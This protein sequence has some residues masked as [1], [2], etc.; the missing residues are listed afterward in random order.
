MM[1]GGNI[2]VHE[3]H[4]NGHSTGTS[5]GEF[6]LGL[7][8]GMFLLLVAFRLMLS[9]SCCKEAKYDCG[10]QPERPDVFLR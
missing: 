3:N 9:S 5:K 1:L 10:V 2:R 8:L 7:A 6:E 4:D